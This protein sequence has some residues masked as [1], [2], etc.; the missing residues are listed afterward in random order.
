[1][2]TIN[3][4]F[5]CKCVDVFCWRRHL[6]GC[7]TMIITN[8][9]TFPYD[10]VEQY[11]SKQSHESN[12]LTKKPLL[13]KQHVSCCKCHCCGKRPFFLSTYL[14]KSMRRIPTTFGSKYVCWV[15]QLLTLW[16]NFFILHKEHFRP[17]LI[18]SKY[19]HVWKF[20]TNGDRAIFC[21]LT[22]FSPK[23]CV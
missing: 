7:F 1:M 4:K 18:H 20:S 13:R 11:K 6:L 14:K 17:F 8:F 15:L 5:F 23:F 22:V 3:W 21:T 12:H 9:Q 2:R 19:F 10:S 16:L